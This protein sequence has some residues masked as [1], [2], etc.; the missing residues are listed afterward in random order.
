MNNL[1]QL[2]RVFKAVICSVVGQIA[3]LLRNPGCTIIVP[4][5][6]IG[7][8]VM[9]SAVVRKYKEFDSKRKFCIG[10]DG[11][12]KGDC[13]AA[14][15]VGTP[16]DRIEKHI[17]PVFRRLHFPGIHKLWPHMWSV[18]CPKYGNKN[19]IDLF[20]QLVF[21]KSLIIKAKP[22]CVSFKNYNLDWSKYPKGRT[23]LICPG[24][25]SAA[26]PNSDEIWMSV[27]N[28]LKQKGFSVVF[29]AE[30]DAHCKGFD[31][32]F[33]DVKTTAAFAEHAGYVI[34][35]RSGL[36]DLLAY[37]TH[38]K[39]LAIYSHSLD[40][41]CWTVSDVWRKEGYVEAGEEFLRYWSLSGLFDREGLYDCFYEGIDDLLRQVDNLLIKEC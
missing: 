15:L 13:D 5:Y 2:L 25:T 30:N 40:D 20:S 17:P 21:G 18:N 8:I 10:I 35:L 37:V 16:F 22:I 3:L 24:A 34:S 23:I 14:E 9:L 36:A 41:W 29:N 19:L 26:M 27:G 39:I 7:D 38:A 33:Y 32:I 6:A 31:T 11:N 28:C 4:G 1:L 12:R